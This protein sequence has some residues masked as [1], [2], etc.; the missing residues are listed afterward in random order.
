MRLFSLLLLGLCGVCSHVV[1][2]GLSV[3]LSW[4]SYVVGA[5]TVMRVLLFVWDVSML[6]VRKC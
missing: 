4:N 3:R 6:R 5:V 2:L 1:V